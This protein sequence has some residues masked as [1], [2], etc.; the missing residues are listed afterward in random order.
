MMTNQDVLNLKFEIAPNLKY[1][2][3]EEGLV[4][5]LERQNHVIQK[6]FR[7]LKVKIPEYKRI[8]MDEYASFVF[9]QLDGHSNVEEIGKK[10]QS[11]YGDEAHPLYE[12]LLLFLNHID[13]NCNYI[14]K[15]S[16]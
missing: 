6:I 3:N 14:M 16:E 13:K 1:E 9:L 5:I 12:R 11:V 15:S 8:S 2:I 7:K 10:I 4:T